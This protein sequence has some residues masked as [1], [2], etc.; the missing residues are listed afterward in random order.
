[1]GLKGELKLSFKR[2]KV[3]LKLNYMQSIIIKKVGLC[4]FIFLAMQGNAQ[5]ITTKQEAVDYL[6]N[7]FVNNV[8]PDYIS[9]VITYTENP[10]GDRIIDRFEVLDFKLKNE[11]IVFTIK[12]NK[13]IVISENSTWRE[14]DDKTGALD[15][16]YINRTDSII[17]EKSINEF[18]KKK[19][20]WFLR[21][22]KYYLNGYFKY[23]LHCNFKDKEI[24]EINNKIETI[25]RAFN[26]LKN[27]YN[28]NEST[29]HKLSEFKN[30]F[31]KSGNSAKISED[32]RKFIVQANAQNEAKNY[33]VALSLYE[34]AMDV[35]QFSYPS[36]YYNMALIASQL[37]DYFYAIYNMKKY[38]IL[39]GPDAP[40]A[41]AVQDKIYEWEYKIED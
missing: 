28:P 22:K 20:V 32:Q 15:Y 4:F 19:F 30:E 34:K 9:D 33:P 29:N 35:N 18:C 7:A 14:V 40:D 36:A 27:T 5:E 25:Y 3:N 39:T 41:R 17:L 26:I 31:L 2:K 11:Y 1:M 37:N 13:Q 6:K 16:L 38:L 23:V 8:K 12:R 24:A 21:Y 10:N